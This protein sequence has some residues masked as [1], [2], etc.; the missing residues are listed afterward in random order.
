MSHTYSVPGT[1]LVKCFME[2]ESR[3]QPSGVEAVTILLL[4]CKE[5]LTLRKF[6]SFSQGYIAGGIIPASALPKP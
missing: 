6:S 3:L 1:V 2:I 4:L 5:K